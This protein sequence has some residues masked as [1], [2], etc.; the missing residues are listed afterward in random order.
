MEK[1]VLEI[2]LEKIHLIQFEMLKEFD[3]FCK[4][5]NFQY[6]LAC[7]SV[8]GA[9]R[10]NGFVPWD[11]DL[12][13]MMLRDE[14]EKM[15]ELIVDE[16]PSQ[17]FL[18]NHKSDPEFPL[19]F[20]KIRMN[21]TVY[22]EEEYEGLDMHHGIYIDIFPID[23]TSK[24]KIG[25]LYHRAKVYLYQIIKRYRKKETVTKS[26]KY[27]LIKLIIHKFAKSIDKEVLYKR[28]HKVYTMYIKKKDN[29]LTIFFGIKGKK[30]IMSQDTLVPAKLKKFMS[31]MA[32]VPNQYELY[33][34]K[35]Y[36][37]YNKLPP[38]EKRKPFLYHK[39][40]YFSL[41]KYGETFFIDNYRNIK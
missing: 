18:Q 8:L 1:S 4:N 11:D 25:Q 9:V 37:D 36:G 38:E 6:W 26:K 12:D 22:Q 10:H 29:P 39:I 30:Y 15:L 32:P 41:G 14:Y 2:E 24:N 28:M 19:F 40:K 13:I 21:N 27:W 7:G 34:T 23:Y 35:L 33:L 3:K 31:I 17:L 20:S 16:L 5:H